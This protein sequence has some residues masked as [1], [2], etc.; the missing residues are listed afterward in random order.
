MKKK[1][2]YVLVC[3]FI[4]M[5]S[6]TV[7][8]AKYVE[9]KVESA[10][11]LLNE[12]EII[13][14][15]QNS[16]K[17]MNLFVS[18][19]RKEMKRYIKQNG[20]GSFFQEESVEI[21]MYEELSEETGINSA[22]I[23]KTEIDKYSSFKIYYV[24][25]K[26]NFKQGN[27]ISKDDILDSGINFRVYV[28]VQEKGKWKIL[29][30]S[31]PI[32]SEIVKAE[33]GMN[34]IEEKNEMKIQEERGKMNLR[35]LSYTEMDTFE[36]EVKEKINTNVLSFTKNDLATYKTTSLNCPAAITVYFTKSGNYGNYKAPRAGINFTTYLKNVIPKELTVSHYKKYPSYLKAGAMACKMY[37]WYYATYPK[38]N[39]SPYYAC[40]KD[41]SS[42]QNYYYN[43][44]S[45][46]NSTY[47]GYVDRTLKSINNKAMVVSGTNSIFEV[48]YH[49]SKGTKHSGMLNQAEA[50]KMAKSGKTYPEILH[51]YYDCSSYTNNKKMK[52]KTY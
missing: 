29:R 26:I 39:F 24:K 49:A 28:L 35:A 13:I 18:E 30:I 7:S 48:H 41:N 25:E 27:N 20:K 8:Q 40:V 5:T 11:N 34:T 15:E 21:L 45:S 10:E 6:E 37:G 46:L 23:E 16:E 42:D 47:R 2:L 1:I 3:C 44:Y 50:L 17:Y 52:I 19:I 22:Y 43:A 9:K 51:Y 32:I 12:Y 31:T 38:W 36:E 33:E 14:E 4:L